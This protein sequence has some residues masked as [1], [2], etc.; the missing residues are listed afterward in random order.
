[1][2]FNLNGHPYEED[3]EQDKKSNESV[4]SGVKHSDH[5]LSL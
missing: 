4:T 2:F 3:H 5:Y 1:M